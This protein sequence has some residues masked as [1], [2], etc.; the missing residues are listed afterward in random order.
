MKK[1]GVV[2][3][4]EGAWDMVVEAESEDEAHDKAWAEFETLSA[5]DLAWGL[6]DAE[7]DQIYEV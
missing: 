3:H 4:Y 2:I 1:Y 5:K 7:T 6:G